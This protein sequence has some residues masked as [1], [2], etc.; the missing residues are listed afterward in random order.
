MKKG[1]TQKIDIKVL[2]EI[3]NS[4][5]FTQEYF[6][7]LIGI[8]REGYRRILKTGITSE[9]TF[10]TILD[11]FNLD[12]N[13][14]IPGKKNTLPPFI[15]VD[16]RFQ[17]SVKYL[18]YITGDIVRIVFT[19]DIENDKNVVSVIDNAKRGVFTDSVIKHARFE[20]IKLKEE[21]ETPDECEYP[22]YNEIE[23]EAIFTAIE[24]RNL[25]NKMNN[26]SKAFID[27]YV[28]FESDL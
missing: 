9:N 28:T 11:V 7:E 3:R 4:Y 27:N 5:R 14:L 8:S 26:M 15:Q 21:I 23:K 18:E 24:F 10:N 6:S 12:K 25:I 17:N 22:K 19:G 2:E 16:K 1:K 13:Y 20:L